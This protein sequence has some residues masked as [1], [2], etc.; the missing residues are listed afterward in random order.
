M[1]PMRIS[2][3][4]SIVAGAILVVAAASCAAPKSEVHQAGASREEGTIYVVK[5]TTLQSAFDV[6]ATAAPIEQAALSTKLMGTILEVTA[7]EGEVV[8]AGQVLVRIDARDLAAKADQLTAS[9]AEAEAIQREAVTHANRIRA[10]FADSAATRAQLDAAETAVARADAAVRTAHAAASELA[11]T[12]TYAVVRAP[13]AGIVTKRLVDVG[14]FAAPGA[15][16]IVVQ[17]VRQLRLVGSATPELAS[18][19][20]RGQR[21]GATIEGRSAVAVVEGVVPAA[22]GNLSTINAVV[23]NVGGT[24]LVGSAATLAVPAAIHSALVVPREA[25][26]RQGDLIG[27]TVRTESGDDTRWVRIG[28][29]AGDMVEVNAG[30]RAGDHVVVP[31]KTAATVAARN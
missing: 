22:A 31:S 10:L 27:V 11:A 4:K 25:L 12:T 13:F 6:S 14:A 19:L 3:K 8:A 15:P 26:I 16:L 24:A 5:D 30:L 18:S 23:E 28:P 20:R 1:I 7:R 29:N 9:A 21:I 2:P 17:N